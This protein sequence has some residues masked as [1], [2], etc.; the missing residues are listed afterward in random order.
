MFPP[1]MQVRAFDKAMAE[2]LGL[3][4]GEIIDDFR[5]G[6]TTDG[7]MTRVTFKGSAYLPTD[8]VLAMFNGAGQS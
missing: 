2:R 3:D 6:F 1:K 8:E 5:V 7:D 4:P